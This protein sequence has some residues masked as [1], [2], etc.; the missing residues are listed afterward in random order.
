MIDGA[1]DDVTQGL[2]PFAEQSER[3]ALSGAGI[4]ADHDVFAVSDSE[5]DAA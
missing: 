5:L 1:D 4:A 3:D 2:E